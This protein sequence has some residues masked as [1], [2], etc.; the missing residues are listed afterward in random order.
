VYAVVR[1]APHPGFGDATARVGHVRLAVNDQKDH[2][3][4]RPYHDRPADCDHADGYRAS[5]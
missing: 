3:G 5:S 2:F 1:P 4:G